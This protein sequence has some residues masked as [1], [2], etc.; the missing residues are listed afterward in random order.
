MSIPKE[1]VLHIAS[2]SRLKL[3]EAEIIAYQEQMRQILDYVQQLENL[4]TDSV[5]PR[6]NVLSLENVVRPDQ[7]NLKLS[8][9]EVF[10]NASDTEGDFFRVPQILS[11]ET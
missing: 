3:S 1:E 4:N 11:Q 2:L 6:S 8:P 5:L 7:V 10:M 9:E